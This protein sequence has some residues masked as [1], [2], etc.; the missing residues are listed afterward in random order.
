MSSK[1]IVAFVTLLVT[2]SFASTASAEKIVL[3]A[4]GGKAE[5]NQPAKDAFVGAPFGTSID[6][7][8][9]LYIAEYQGHRVRKVDSKGI[10]TTVGGTGKAGFSGDGGPATKSQFNAMHDLV[11]AENGDIYIADSNNVRV[12]KIDAK[13]GVLSTVAGTGKKEVTGDGGPGEKAGLDGVAS[14]F[15]DPSGTKLYITGFS[16][17]V[18][19][20]DIK[21]GIIDT[22]KNLPGGRSVAVDSKGNVYVAGG[23]ILRVLRPD[24]KI[25][26]LLGPK[27]ADAPEI[28]LGSNPKHMAIDD[29]GDVLIA[30]DFGHCIKK[31]LVAEKKLVMFAGKGTKGTSG[32][33]GP[34]LEVEMNAPHGVHFHAATKTVYICDSMNK[35]VLK[36]EP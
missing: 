10:I 14:I 8:G 21:T 29:K 30:D 15:F 35:R 31:Y 7:D 1:R 32:L 23:T 9:S 36:I 20:L 16:K 33:N 27:K 12:R 34:P 19:I 13:T 25:E 24:G 11:L 3:V 18:R 17:V 28:S 22:V 2:S 26:V 5:D 4:G 6:K